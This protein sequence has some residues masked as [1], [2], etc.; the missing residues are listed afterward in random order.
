MTRTSRILLWGG[1]LCALLLAGASPADAQN[2][3][4]TIRVDAARNRRPINP[5]VYGVAGADGTT[6]ADLNCPLNRAGGNAATCYN[7]QLNAANRADDW[8]YES[9]G[10]PSA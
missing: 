1:A 4:V 10:Y 3:A 5:G 8:Y 2:P 9:I 7:W 6:L